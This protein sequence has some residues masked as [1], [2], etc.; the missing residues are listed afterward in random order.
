MRSLQR[1]PGGRRVLQPT[2]GRDGV[3]GWGRMDWGHR[4]S[5]LYYKPPI[6]RN[7]VSPRATEEPPGS[8]RGR[9]RQSAVGAFACLQV[10][11][12]TVPQF[13]RNRE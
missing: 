5:G 12:V 1:A 4:L 8:P 6:A 3:G 13:P 10:A 11:R 2:V 9:G 7:A